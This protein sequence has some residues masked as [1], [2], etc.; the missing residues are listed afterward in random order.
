M[1][2]QKRYVPPAYIPIGQSDVE[3]DVV[4]PAAVGVP[5]PQRIS[6]GPGQW[7]SGICACFDDI[8]S[9]C[10]GLFCPCYLFAKNAE[11]L[12]SGTIVGSCMTHFILWGLVNTLCCVLTDGFMLG[13]PGCFVACYACGYRGTLRSNYN[14]EEAPCG[15]FVTHFFCHLCAL[16][17]EHRE[18]R[19]R[20]RD[21]N[22]PALNLAEVR[23]PAV[24]T[25]ESAPAD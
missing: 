6:N 10:V 14:L 5:T 8:Q 24:Q 12:G 7:S 22:N 17:Q 13:L 11:F 21:S 2:G 23:A 9:C 4:P 19:E 15:D 20:S 25:M 3:A 18:I 16:C 1:V